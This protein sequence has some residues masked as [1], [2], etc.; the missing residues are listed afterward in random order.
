MRRAEQ[1]STCVSMSRVKVGEALNSRTSSSS[2]LG[3][4]SVSAIG[5]RSLGGGGRARK[6]SRASSSGTS[7]D[8]PRAGSNSVIPVASVGVGFGEGPEINGVTLRP[9]RFFLDFLRWAGG[10]QTSADGFHLS[11]WKIRRRGSARHFLG[12]ASWGA[13]LPIERGFKEEKI[14]V[15]FL[16]TY[17]KDR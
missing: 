13:V 1:L 6:S 8:S 16:R 17:V 11:S 12:L 9:R 15:T 5:E 14:S 7:P 4:A 3:R 10:N 2:E